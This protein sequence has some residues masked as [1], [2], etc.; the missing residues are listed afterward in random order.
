[1]L[2]HAVELM[3]Q[4]SDRVLPEA[5]IGIQDCWQGFGRWRCAPPTLEACPRSHEHFCGHRDDKHTR[6]VFSAISTPCRQ[7]CGHPEAK[8]Q[9]QV[10]GKLTVRLRTAVA[11]PTLKPKPKALNPSLCELQWRG[12]ASVRV[13]GP[14]ILCL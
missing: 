11:V 8:V 1:M 9:D 10:C 2:V 3:S 14:I 6:F 7:W 4:R 12:S 5:H 13:W